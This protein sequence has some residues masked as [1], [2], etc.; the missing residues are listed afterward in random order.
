MEPLF[1]LLDNGQSYWL[2]NLSRQM[3]RDGSL[4]RRVAMEGLRGVTSNPAIFHKAISGGTLYA[5]QIAA[6][7]EA[8]RSVGEIYEELAVDDVRDACDVLR[9]VWQESDGVD[10]YVSL[11]VSP[12][13]VHDAAGSIAEARRLWAAVDRPNLMVKIP[14]TPAGVSAIEELLFDGVNINVTL[15]FSIAAY[16]A[17]HEAYIRALGRRRE[18]GRPLG[19]VASVASFFLSRIDVLVDGLLSQRIDR[20]V[21]VAGAGPASLF[22]TS[23]IASARLAYRSF[24]SR[25]ATDDWDRLAQAGARPQRLLWASTST[26]NPLYDPV[27]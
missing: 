3:L 14:G 15:L 25:L 6:L 23:A 18:A 12:H 4:E 24:E 1:E 10:G 27:R 7:A 22:G 9:P 2:D 20:E 21:G 17:V 8:G 5:D 16:E 19:T 11:E 26:K 13:L